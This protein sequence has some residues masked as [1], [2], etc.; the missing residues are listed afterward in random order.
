[1]INFI[2]RLMQ[3]NWFSEILPE[4]LFLGAMP[5]DEYEVQQ[6]R[7]NGVT[8]ILTIQEE[9]EYETDLPSFKKFKWRRLSIRDSNLGGLP[10]EKQLGNAA[11]IL[12]QWLDVE[13][14]VVYIHCYAGQGR[15]PL[16]TMAYLSLWQNMSPDDAIQFVRDKR[17]YARPTPGQIQIL[18]SLLK[19][20]KNS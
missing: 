6:L 8:A 16:V 11:E 19:K 12:H 20:R 1:M 14:H 15:S 18:R 3:P 5:F 2:A 13:H 7:A 4:K 10:T 17:E 9:N